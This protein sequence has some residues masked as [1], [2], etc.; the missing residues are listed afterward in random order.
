MIMIRLFFFVDRQF[1]VDQTVL[2]MDEDYDFFNDDIEEA[3]ELLKDVPSPE[4]VNCAVLGF[5]AVMLP[6]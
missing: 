5:Q 4:A 1:F 6:L 3:R 2:V